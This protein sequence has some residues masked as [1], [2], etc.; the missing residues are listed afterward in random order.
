MLVLLALVLLRF[1]F[2]VFVLSGGALVA[3][4][5]LFLAIFVRKLLKKKRSVKYQI[6]NQIHSP[7]LSVQTR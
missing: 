6:M 7:S 3:R 4:M 5:F 2:S 1:T